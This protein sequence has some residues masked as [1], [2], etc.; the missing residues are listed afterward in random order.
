MLHL[1]MAPGL[2]CLP[3]TTPAENHHDWQQVPMQ[4]LQLHPG[5]ACLAW[6]APLT[7]PA[8]TAGWAP[9]GCQLTAACSLPFVSSRRCRQGHPLAVGQR[10]ACCVMVQCR[11]GGWEVQQHIKD[12]AAGLGSGCR[13]CSTIAKVGCMHRQGK[14]GKQGAKAGAARQARSVKRC[15][16]DTASEMRDKCCSSSKH[17][18]FSLGCPCSLGQACNCDVEAGQ[19]AAPGVRLEPGVG[20]PGHCFIANLS[21][22]LPDNASTAPHKQATEHSLP[23][24]VVAGC[25]DQ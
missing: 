17:K 18:E 23:H 10:G 6:P 20:P 16:G 3:L 24:V 12:Q 14:R 15:W 19:N 11:A 5:A 2:L 21:F 9:S 25:K 4:T 1:N 13:T 8:G 22:H 7:A